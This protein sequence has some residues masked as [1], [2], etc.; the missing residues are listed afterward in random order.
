MPN[1]HDPNELVAKLTYLAAINPKVL[2]DLKKYAADV[3][4]EHTKVDI[5]APPS[6][7][8]FCCTAANL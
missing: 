8:Y 3:L 7:I 1:I 6:P 2:E 5:N 4:T